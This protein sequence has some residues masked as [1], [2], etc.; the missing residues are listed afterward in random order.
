[1]ALSTYSDLTTSVAG[2]LHRADLTNAIPDFIT[3]AESK[4]YNRLRIRDMET[5]V[6]S[7]M[8]A[9]VVAV[10]TS[11]VELKDAYISS[12]SPYGRLERKTAEW[13]YERYPFRT[14]DRQP[15][16]LAREGSNFI[17]GPFPDSN[18]TVTLVFW[19]KLPTLSVSTN[20]IWTAYPGLWLY[21]SLLEAA[22]Y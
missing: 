2:W 15:G 17:F 11:Y 18:Y 14:A 8:A 3:L 7:T 1:M 4:I 6:A 16:Y 22:P 9:G 12:T 21:G 13:I 19:N 20:S 10:P 5:S